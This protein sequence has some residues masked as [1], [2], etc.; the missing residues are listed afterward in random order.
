MCSF[1][2]YEPNRNYFNIAKRKV[3]A[4]ALGLV[5]GGVILGALIAIIVAITT[6]K[7]TC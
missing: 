4:L 6:S 2:D 1:Q 3:Y 7:C 5:I